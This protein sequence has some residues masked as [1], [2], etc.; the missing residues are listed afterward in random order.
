MMELPEVE[1]VTERLRL[2]LTGE[3]L[4][5]IHLTRASA[6]RASPG[7]PASEL[8]ALSGARVKSVT[9][10]GRDLLFGFD[11]G[12]VLALGFGAAGHAEFG[13]TVRPAPDEVLGLQFD[14]GRASL[15]E[16]TD[17]HRCQVAIG[18]DPRSLLRVGELGPD[19]LG[20]NFGLDRLRSL[21]K[22]RDRPLRRLL[23]DMHS[24]AG[25]GPACADEILFESRL[26]PLTLTSDLKPE[27][28]IRL[29]MAIKKVLQSA[30]VQYRA[31]PAE[32]LPDGRDRPFLRVH[33]LHGRQCPQCGAAIRSVR[34]GH[35]IANYCPHCQAGDAI[36]ADLA[37]QR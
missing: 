25:L 29:H 6:F 17:S 23:T 3:R 19:P 35:G 11:S 34:D 36:L 5:S 27:E 1:V 4:A 9:R 37:P 31:L 8:L 16:P 33:R 32:R 30:L 24:I 2:V 28:P 10:A 15:C 18:T 12:L 26:S 22:R 21:L 20:P 13:D 14:P 7:H